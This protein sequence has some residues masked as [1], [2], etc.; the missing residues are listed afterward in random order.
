[1]TVLCF[2]IARDIVGQSKLTIDREGINSVEGLRHFLIE[3]FPKF[4]EYTSFR[5]AVNQAFASEKDEVTNSDEIAI[6]PP[7]SGG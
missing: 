6:I 4:K 3:T 5:I 2:G 1:M 7:V